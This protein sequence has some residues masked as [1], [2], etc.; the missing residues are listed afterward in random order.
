MSSMSA[1]KMLFGWQIQEIG[2]VDILIVP[3]GGKMTLGGV[4]AA[5]VMH[6]LQATVAIPM[7]YGTKALGLL[8]KIVFAKVDKFIEAVGMRR[9]EVKTLQ[10]S[11]ENLA[12]YKGI[13]TMQ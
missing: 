12:Q 7:H 9:T 2:K 3:V 8:G 13:V 5:Q 11:K 1:L 10:I 6:Q 4:E